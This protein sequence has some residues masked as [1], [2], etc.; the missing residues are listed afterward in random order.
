M[1]KSDCG[2]EP[3]RQPIAFFLPS[4]TCICYDEVAK[5]ISLF[6]VRIVLY[7]NGQTDRQISSSLFQKSVYHLQYIV[8]K[9]SMKEW[10]HAMDTFCN[11]T[12]K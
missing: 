11:Y 1:E 8:K 5:Y 3:I 12:I 10:N 6:S 2:S 4:K 9:H 7:L